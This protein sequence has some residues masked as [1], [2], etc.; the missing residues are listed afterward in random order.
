M[1]PQPRSRVCQCQGDSGTVSPRQPTLRAPA[2]P[3]RK[4]WKLGIG[5]SEGAA[6]RRICVKGNPAQGS[7]LATGRS[8]EGRE[9]G[10]GCP[11]HPR[12]CGSPP[13][14]PH[15]MAV[16]SHPMGE[17]LR[18]MAAP[19]PP[20]N[21]HSQQTIAACKPSFPQKTPSFPKKNHSQKTN[22]PSKP[23]LPANY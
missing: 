12:G 16:R 15:P 21:Q 20:A 19:W 6:F 14:S 2:I 23:S 11:H 13:R 17:F 18:G 22:I 9:R 4:V 7:L 1:S 10:Q 5:E 8:Q 3:I